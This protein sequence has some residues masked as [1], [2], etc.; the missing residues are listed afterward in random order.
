MSAERERVI[1]LVMSAFVHFGKVMKIFYVFGRERMCFL[2]SERK[3]VGR[4][5]VLSLAEQKMC[6]L[7]FNLGRCMILKI[8][9]DML[10]QS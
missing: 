10:L 5:H 8:I 4:E 2:L 6:L 9:L 3:F 1:S 7:L